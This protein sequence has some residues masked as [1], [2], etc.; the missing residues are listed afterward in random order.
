[1]RSVVIKDLKSG[2]KIPSGLRFG[3]ICD[4]DVKA[5]NNGKAVTISR[6]GWWQKDTLPEESVT[7][8]T[9]QRKKTVNMDAALAALN[10]EKGGLSSLAAGAQGARVGCLTDDEYAKVL[11]ELG[12]NAMASDNADYARKMILVKKVQLFRHLAQGALDKLV[13][14][15]Q[16][17]TFKKG[18]FVIKQGEMGTKFYVIAS[19][20]VGVWIGDKFIRTMPRNQFFGERALLFDESRTATVKVTTNEA[21][22]W[23]IDKSMFTKTITAKL[24]QELIG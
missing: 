22:L 1:M 11:K 20:E 7:H 6:G 4:G 17:E 2:D 8:D 23:S 9:P 18:E 15:F 12:L 14:G 13:N 19:G 16:P 24:Q 10:Q 3:C 21:E 5:T